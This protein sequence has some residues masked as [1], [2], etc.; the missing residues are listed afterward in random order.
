M[1]QV[2]LR[3]LACHNTAT[4]NRPSTKITWEKF[5]TESQANKPPFERGKSRCGNA[6]P[7]LRPYRLMI[8]AV[9]LAAR[10]DHPPTE[11]VAALRVDQADLKQLIERIAQARKMAA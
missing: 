3:K 5:R 2:V 6:A 1:A 10:E 9:G 11:G 7:M 4:S 8:W